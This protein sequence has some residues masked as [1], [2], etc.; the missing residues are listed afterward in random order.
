[1]ELKQEYST[2]HFKKNPVFL[3]WSMY[4]HL[5]SGSCIKGI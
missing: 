5:Q 4:S 1:M 3:I 2:G